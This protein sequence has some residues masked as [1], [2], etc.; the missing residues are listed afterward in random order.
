MEPVCDHQLDPALLAHGLHTLRLVRVQP[1]RLLAQDVDAGT[2]RPDHVLA[3]PIVGH[4]NVHRVHLAT[5][6]ILV[7]LVIAQRGVDAVFR[8]QAG[9]LRLVVREDRP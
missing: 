5:S 9:Q 7:V 1:E 3:V 2:R 6:E 4:G 8:A